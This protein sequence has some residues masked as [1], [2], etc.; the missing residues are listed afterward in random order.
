MKEKI[1]V[2][3]IYVRYYETDRMKIVHHSNYFRYFELA[4]CNFFIKKIV[5]YSILEE[6]YGILSPLLSA[7]AQFFKPLKFE[8]VFKIITFISSFNLTRVTFEYI[9]IFC[10][11]PNPNSQSICGDKKIEIEECIDIVQNFLNVGQ[12]LSGLICVGKTEHTFVDSKSFKP[13]RPRVFIEEKGE[14]LDNIINR[15]RL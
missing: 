6:K 7:S 8:D 4:R 2:T 5:P 11:N 14:E 9:C 10:K 12:K 15:L 13:I 3:E 1:D